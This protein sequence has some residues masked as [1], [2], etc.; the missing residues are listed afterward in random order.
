MVLSSYLVLESRFGRK[1]LLILSGWMMCVCL[2]VLGYY[3]KLK[4]EGNDVSSIGWIPLLSLAL[5]N[6]VFSAGY[7]TVPYSIITELF[8]PETKGIAS[9]ISI[10]TNWFLVFVVT[11]FFPIMVLTMGQAMTFWFFSVMCG[12]SGIFGFF[13]P[14]T[15]GKTLQEIQ[16]KLARTRDKKTV[17]FNLRKT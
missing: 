5:F 7:G 15:K 14:E 11:K 1:P 13:V 6:V 2:G 10:M 12:A 17:F 16:E 4:D 9:S 3:F 8:P